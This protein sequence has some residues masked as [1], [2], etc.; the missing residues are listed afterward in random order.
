MQKQT[1]SKESPHLVNRTA[2]A[3]HFGLSAATTAR[4]RIDSKSISAVPSFAARRRSSWPGTVKFRACVGGTQMRCFEIHRIRT[5]IIIFSSLFSSAASSPSS[6]KPPTAF[7]AFISRDLTVPSLM[8]VQAEISRTSCRVM[9][10]LRLVSSS[11][12]K[13][14]FELLPL[15]GAF[16]LPHRAGGMNPRYPRLSAHQPAFRVLHGADNRA[17]CLWTRM[18]LSTVG[19]GAEIG[20]NTFRKAI[21]IFRRLPV[22]GATQGVNNH[23][24]CCRNC[25]R[26]C[27][28]HITQFAPIG[29][30][31]FQKNFCCGKN[32]KDNTRKSGKYLLLRSQ[33]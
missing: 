17:R 5:E 28:I 30:V 22:F 31:I 18:T 23:Y 27:P 11:L 4:R 15:F 8:P 12:S 7:L 9:M 13:S 19:Q 32:P 2:Y 33:F 26:F 1:G 20:K 25:G 6:A 16:Q 10:T 29:R 14:R 21:Y 3:L 24:I